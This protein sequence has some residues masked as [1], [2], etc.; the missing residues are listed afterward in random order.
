MKWL[1]QAFA[2][3]LLVTALATSDKAWASAPEFLMNQENGYSLHQ[4]DGSFDRQACE[5]Y[6]RSFY[7]LLPY[8]GGGGSDYG[9]GKFYLFAK[10]MAD[11]DRK[12]WKEFDRKS[13]SLE[14]E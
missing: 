3:I 9:R 1:P 4:Y 10:C 14:E 2:G 11:C 13:R 8:A 12:F 6:C 5:E 7:G